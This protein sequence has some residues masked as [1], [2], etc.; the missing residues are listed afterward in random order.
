[1]SSRTLHLA[2]VY[3]QVNLLVYT[4]PVFTQHTQPQSVGYSRRVCNL[5]LT[6]VVVKKLHSSIA[7]LKLYSEP[8][9]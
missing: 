4:A 9:P 5:T 2:E 6:P 1:M 7:S 8:C 3:S